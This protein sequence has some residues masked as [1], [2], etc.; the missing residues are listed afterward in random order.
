MAAAPTFIKRKASTAEELEAEPSEPTA[1]K[2]V[3]ISSAVP[4]PG[5]GKDHEAESGTGVDGPRR[6]W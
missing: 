1:K 2:Q 6:R 5:P 4:L 3:K